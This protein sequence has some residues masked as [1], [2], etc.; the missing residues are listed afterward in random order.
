MCGSKL[1]ARL[2]F[3]STTILLCGL[4]RP[5]TPASAQ[6]VTGYARFTR[7]QHHRRRQIPPTIALK[8]HRSNPTMVGWSL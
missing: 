8:F 7:R 6:Q 3:A 5:L 4:A 2:S 1:R